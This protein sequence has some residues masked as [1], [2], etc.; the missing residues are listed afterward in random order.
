[1]E[2]FSND[3][4]FRVVMKDG[5]EYVLRFGEIA[6]PPNSDEKQKDKRSKRARKR[7]ATRTKRRRTAE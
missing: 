2:L 7:M 1:M 4:E 3:G 6:G 5:V